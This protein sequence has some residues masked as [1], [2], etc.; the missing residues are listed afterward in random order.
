MVYIPRYLISRVLFLRKISSIDPPGDARLT[1]WEAA[2]ASY[3]REAYI[4]NSG[5]ESKA[6]AKT[7]PL[8]VLSRGSTARLPAV[9]ILRARRLAHSIFAYWL[10][11]NQLSSYTTGAKPEVYAKM[12]KPYAL[13]AVGTQ[14]PEGNL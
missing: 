13:R 12:G 2:L 9:T 3:R 6:I 4:Y 10:R 7:L 14:I 1:I 8:A 5:R 11:L